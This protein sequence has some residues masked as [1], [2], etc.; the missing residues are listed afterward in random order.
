MGLCHDFG[1]PISDHCTHPMRAGAA[2]CTCDECGVVCTGLFDACSDVWARGPHPVLLS[3]RPRTDVRSPVVLPPANGH[4]RP[5][6]GTTDPPPP[7]SQSP[8]NQSPGN[9]SPANQSPVPATSPPS[10]PLRAA[11]RWRCA[12]PRPTRRGRRCTAGSSG[13]SAPCGTR[14]PVC[15]LRSAETRQDGTP[16]EGS[17]PCPRWPTRSP[18]CAPPSSAK[19]AGTG[20]RQP[21]RR[22]AGAGRTGRRTTGRS[23]PEAG[24]SGLRQPARRPAGDGPGGRGEGCRRARPGTTGGTGRRQEAR[25]PA[26]AGRRG[27]PPAGRR[28]PGPRAG[29]GRRQPARRPSGDGPGGRGEG[30]PS[31]LD[32]SSSRSP[33]PSRAFAGS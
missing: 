9:Q 32:P 23:G 8:A 22:P 28:G 15:E 13:S 6:R 26:R 14:S 17:T 29:P 18:A 21:A 30:C 3:R 16:T 10:G 27:R 5:R 31:H 4:Q 25:R 2:S 24:S 20:R 12:Q 7:S 19:G 11:A 1:S 33:A